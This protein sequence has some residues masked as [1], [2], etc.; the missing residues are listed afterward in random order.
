[1]TACRRKAVIKLRD[2]NCAAGATGDGGPATNANLDN[3]Y[4][5]T[6]DSSGSIYIADAHNNAIRKVIFKPKTI[7]KWIKFEG[8]TPV[9]LTIV[10]NSFLTVR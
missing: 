6:V 2:S 1:M 3:P 9:K 5:I 10:G 8:G 7:I 4:D